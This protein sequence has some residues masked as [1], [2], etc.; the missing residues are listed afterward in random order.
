MTHDESDLDTLDAF[1]AEA[2]DEDI[3]SILLQPPRTPSFA[4][5]TV[6]PRPS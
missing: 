3:L 6:R 2:L 4:R 5:E 1:L